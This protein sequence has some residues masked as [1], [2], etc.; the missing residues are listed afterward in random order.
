VQVALTALL[1]M[2]PLVHVYEYENQMI[3]FHV[4]DHECLQEYATHLWPEFGCTFSVWRPE[5]SCPQ[6]IFGQDE[7]VFS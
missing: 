6:I 7:S 4:D 3:E 1:P 5:N 2:K